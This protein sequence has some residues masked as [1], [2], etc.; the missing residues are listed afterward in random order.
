[1]LYNDSGPDVYGLGVSA[2][3]LDFIVG[4]SSSYVWYMG[5]AEKMRLNNSG[6]LSISSLASGGTAPT[7][8]GTTKMVV[9]DA[10]GLLSFAAIPSGGGA[11][12]PLNADTATNG[13]II[14]INSAADP[15]LGY[16]GTSNVYLGKA[17]G[18]AM[19]GGGTGRM[20]VY[21]GEGAGQNAAGKF[22]VFIG[23]SAGQNATGT[24]ASENT[25]IGNAAGVAVTTGAYNSIM[26]SSAGQSTTTG[27]SN[28]IIGM[29]AGRLNTT[30]SGNVYLGSGAGI[31]STTGNN[32]ILIGTGSTAP[33]AGTSNYLNIGDGTNGSVLYG[34]LSTGNLTLKGTLTQLSDKRLK[35]D[36][37]PLS[38]SLNKVL[39]LNG[40][41][42]HWKPGFKKDSREYVGFL[43]QD[44][45]KIVP[46]VVYQNQRGDHQD[47]L[48]VS[49]EQLTPLLV[50]AIKEQQKIIED[51]RTRNIAQQ[52]E[53]DDLK[54]RMDRMEKLLAGGT[55][56]A[57]QAVL[58]P[59]EQPFG[60]MVLFAKI[61]AFFAGLFT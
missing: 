52:A 22:N 4:S 35:T 7:T 60:L 45:Q 48:S 5:G 46:Q 33:T 47:Y 23:W 9:T 15:F 24:N 34:D 32:N 20:N 3:Q 11:S 30:G 8:S 42:Y 16:R 58:A 19:D 38:G 54:T 55:N 1:R 29:N 43:A 49:Y 53:I 26:G 10:N 18:K 6:N 51:E 28:T 21:I 17:A 2:G 40:V 13:R 61:K 39:G 41:S 27:A 57:K 12:L 56:D 14:E 44:V 50:E 59:V 25:F 36:I 37:A 31:T